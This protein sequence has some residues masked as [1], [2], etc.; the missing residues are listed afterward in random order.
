M[1]KIIIKIKIKNHNL[2]LLGIYL[3]YDTCK[4][5]VV[6][7]QPGYYGED[8]KQQCN[9][10]C[11]VTTQCHKVTGQCEGGCKPGW[12]GNMCDHSMDFYLLYLKHSN[13]L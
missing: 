2:I 11:N 3:R 1:I 6:V 4:W 5:T 13:N 8:C 10:N 9:I 12:T 7:C